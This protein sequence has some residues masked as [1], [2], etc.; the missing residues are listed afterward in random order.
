MIGLT[1]FSKL[2]SGKFDENVYIC[3]KCDENGKCKYYHGLKEIESAGVTWVKNLISVSSKYPTI[4]FNDADKTSCL[5]S[6][7]GIVLWI[8]EKM[9]I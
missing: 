8:Q 6:G 5:Y 3:K 7:R 4:T 2:S 1:Q 9:G